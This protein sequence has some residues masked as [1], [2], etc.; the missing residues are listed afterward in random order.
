ML[1]LESQAKRQHTWLFKS[2]G[3]GLSTQNLGQM[4]REFIIPLQGFMLE[5]LFIIWICPLSLEKMCR[6]F[7]KTKSL[8]I[9]YFWLMWEAEEG[10]HAV[11]VCTMSW[12]PITHWVPKLSRC[13]STWWQEE[14]H[15]TCYIW[16][17]CALGGCILVLKGVDLK[18][19]HQNRFQDISQ[20]KT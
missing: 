1:H 15:S 8:H 18:Y 7:M 11:Q 20:R 5:Y 9:E 14:E 16:L 6:Y 19:T 12:T 10:K 17:C 2:S 13:F 4:T 3:W